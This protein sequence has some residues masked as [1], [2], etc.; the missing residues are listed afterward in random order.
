MLPYQQSVTNKIGRLFAKKVLI[1]ST[2]QPD[3][4][5]HVLRSTKERL[6]L[7]FLRHHRC[8]KC[9]HESD[10]GLEAKTD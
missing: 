2:S 5:I 10:S 7:K 9:D 1:P 6:G 3:K 4:N 8:I